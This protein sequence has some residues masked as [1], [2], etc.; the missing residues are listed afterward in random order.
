M[1]C[2]SEYKGRSSI[3][4]I[5]LGKHCAIFQISVKARKQDLTPAEFAHWMFGLC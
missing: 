5:I 4:I 2:K 1:W 3:Y